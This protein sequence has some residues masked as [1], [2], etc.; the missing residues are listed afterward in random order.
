MRDVHALIEKRVSWPIFVQGTAGM[1]GSN[2]GTFCAGLVGA[3]HNNGRGGCGAAP[4]SDLMLIACLGDQVGTDTVRDIQAGSVVLIN[5]AGDEQLLE[6]QKPE[7]F[8][9]Q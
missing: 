6:L 8:P 3:R 9:V 5:E 2:H 4:E 7:R 1:P